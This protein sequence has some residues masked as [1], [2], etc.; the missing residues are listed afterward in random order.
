MLH[1]VRASAF[2]MALQF[3]GS[4]GDS[5]MFRLILTL[6]LGSIIWWVDDDKLMEDLVAGMNGIEVLRSGTWVSLAVMTAT[7]AIVGFGAGFAA[8]M[9]THAMA[10]AG[11]II[12]HD[13]GFA[14]SQ[15]MDPITGR[16][17]AVMSQ[18]FQTLAILLVFAL[19]IHHGF[20]LVLAKTYEWVPVGHGFNIEPVFLRLTELVSYA[21]ATAMEYAFPIMGIL[22]LL[23][24]VLVMLARAVQNINLLEFSFG[25]RIGLGIFASIYFLDEGMPFLEAIAN[26]IVEKSH[27]L[28]EGAA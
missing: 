24:A 20:I 14:M 23:T 28:F 11:E 22:V 15:V 13:M 9:L 6:S 7:D 2:F 10:V 19:N 26:S 4:Q 8:S 12:S 21:L 25:L 16:S 3:F 18:F 1:F 27:D 5:K 17:H